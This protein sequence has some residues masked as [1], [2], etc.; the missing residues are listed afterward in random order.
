MDNNCNN[1][2]TSKGNNCGYDIIMN[3]HKFVYNQSKADIY[4]NTCE[5]LSCD[6]FSG[7]G[8]GQVHGCTVNNPVN[9]DFYC[10]DKNANSKNVAGAGSSAD[11]SHI[12]NTALAKQGGAC[13]NV[14]THDP[15]GDYRNVIQ[16]RDCHPSHRTRK[17]HSGAIQGLFCVDFTSFTHF[18]WFNDK[19][20]CIVFVHNL[21]LQGRGKFCYLVGGASLA[22]AEL[23][24]CDRIPTGEICISHSRVMNIVI[25]DVQCV[26]SKDL[27]DSADP[28][29]TYRDFVKDV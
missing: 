25:F 28:K 2:L 4:F 12:L 22:V 11:C 20:V 3:E 6:N 9:V 29:L 1:C 7:S 26:Y 21:R 18:D 8:C 16:F 10:F 23:V 13:V 14:P 15:L 24:T 5:S 19:R 27:Y 17:G